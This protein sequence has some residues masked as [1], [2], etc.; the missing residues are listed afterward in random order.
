MSN[1]P[2]IP[3]IEVSERA[4]RI[5]ERLHIPFD[6]EVRWY[7]MEEELQRLRDEIVARVDEKAM[8]EGAK[9][10]VCEIIRNHK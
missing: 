7:I 10:D 8:P 3:S 2:S 9:F 4:R 5:V 1:L 6:N